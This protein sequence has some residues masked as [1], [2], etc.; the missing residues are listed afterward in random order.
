MFLFLFLPG[1]KVL[2]NMDI[3]PLPY[4]G[5]HTEQISEITENSAKII[6]FTS[7]KATSQAV[8]GTDSIKN[9][10]VNLDKNFG[11]TSISSQI[12]GDLTYHE[13]NLINLK[14]ETV[15]F[16]RALSYPSPK[17]W[18]KTNPILGQEMSFK[19]KKAAPK[20]ILS[21]NQPKTGHST[22]KPAKKIVADGKGGL[23]LNTSFDDTLDDELSKNKATATDKIGGNQGILNS[24]DKNSGENN[25]EADTV[26]PEVY[27]F[28]G[29]VI[30]AFG[31]Y[32]L[33]RYQ[34]K[35]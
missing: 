8:Y 18:K 31:L 32:F 15:Y 28:F 27:Y 22:K 20:P 17:Q 30:L 26:K 34:Q 5:L 13:I 2:A 21:E 6:W 25:Q 14:P 35:V 12:D 29:I 9:L 33:R 4:M 7:H 23:V 24:T 19:T 16:I 10:L 11:Y 1:R 3:G